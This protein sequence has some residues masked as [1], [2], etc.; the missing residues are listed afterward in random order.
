MFS[1]LYDTYFPFLMNFKMSAICFNLD[2]CQILSSVNRLIIIIIIIIMI[3]LRCI[4]DKTCLLLD[5]RVQDFR[6]GGRW[7]DLGSDDV[8]F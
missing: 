4:N 7:F 3:T 6:T 5:K 1:T 8:L 2:Q